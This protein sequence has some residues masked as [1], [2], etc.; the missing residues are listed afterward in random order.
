MA[1]VEEDGAFGRGAELCPHLRLLQSLYPLWEINET[2]TSVFPSYRDYAQ[3]CQTLVLRYCLCSWAFPLGRSKGLCL[4]KLWETR[5]SST[6]PRYPYS[7]NLT[8]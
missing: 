4:W 6:S 5:E 3:N 2:Q 7:H 1:I 8:T